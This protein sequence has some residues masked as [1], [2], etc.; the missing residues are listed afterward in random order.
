[1]KAF[2]LF[3][4]FVTVGILAIKMDITIVD[5]TYVNPNTAGTML[6]FYI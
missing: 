4:T 1:M 2:K 6:V 5:S 3:G